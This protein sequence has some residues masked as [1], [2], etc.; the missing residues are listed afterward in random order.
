M[1]V[2]VEQKIAKTSFLSVISVIVFVSIIIC[3]QIAV[4]IKRYL[5]IK[6]EEKAERVAISAFKEMGEARMR[7]NSFDLRVLN[8]SMSARQAWADVEGPRSNDFQHS[9]DNI[10]TTK[11]SKQQVQV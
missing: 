3:C 10:N 9:T 11:L 6:A 5:V 4:E 8:P 2:P 7:M 1:R